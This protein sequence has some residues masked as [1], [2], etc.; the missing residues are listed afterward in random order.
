M[1]VTINGK[2]VEIIT[3]I[4][5]PV[6]KWN[7]DDQQVR[8]KDELTIQ[9]NNTLLTL[10]SLAWEKYN[11]HL[12]NKMPINVNIIRDYILAK[13]KP[14][15][16]LMQAIEHQ[17]NNLKGRVGNDIASNTVKK[18]ETI[19][20]KVQNY[21][22]KKLNS[23]DVSLNELSS[24]FIYDFDAYLRI[25]E[26]LSHNA[27]A[28]NMQQFKRVIKVALQNEW[29]VKDPFSNYKCSPKETERGF[30]TEDELQE[31]TNK[32]LNDR[33]DRVR[34]IFLFCCYTGLAYADVSKLSKQHFIKGDDGNTWII[35]SRTKSKS[36][37]LIPV[38]P[39]A[40][41]I[42]AK[43]SNEV[44]NEKILPIISN[45]NLNKYLKEIVLET[46]I[47]KRMSMHLARHT[48][49]TTVTLNKG[50]D[51]V[52]V[53]KMLGHKNLRT[54][55]IYAKTGMIKIAEDIKKLL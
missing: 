30:L 5:I 4:E 6:I 49:A 24:K 22:V 40:A 17:I 8:G 38:L 31:L 34:D 47:T 16:S 53:S 10:K 27:I 36:Q 13:D 46:S 32:K 28:K 44:S 11:Y 35:L 23:N 29:M 51:I 7:S 33:L 19:K 21:L 52:S 15:Y 43:Y 42:M 1:R 37:A 18:Y 55:Q 41:A 54:T 20:R 26:K 39:K 45:Q 2:R 12:R 14:D 9:Y 3:G 25:D 50:V 48:F